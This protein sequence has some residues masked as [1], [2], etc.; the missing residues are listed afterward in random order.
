MSVAI[1]DRNGSVGDLVFEKGH[2]PCSYVDSLDRFEET[3]L[4][5][6]SKF[7]NDMTE[8]EISDRDYEHAQTVWHH[9]RM[10]TFKDYHD[11]I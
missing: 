4:P 10:R 7:Y 8:T 6:K 11:F 5:E 1:C 2:F 3:S 9:F